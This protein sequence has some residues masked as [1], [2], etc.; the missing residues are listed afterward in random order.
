MLKPW[1]ARTA[2]NTGGRGASERVWSEG[3]ETD[4][5]LTAL[6]KISGEEG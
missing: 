5:D 1:V 4:L 6:L 2:K 3:R